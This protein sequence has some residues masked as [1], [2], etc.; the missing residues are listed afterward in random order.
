MRSSC[1]DLH[2]W[3]SICLES[4]QPL[5]SHPSCSGWPA[6]DLHLTSSSRNTLLLILTFTE[7]PSWMFL[8]GVVYDFPRHSCVVFF[9]LSANFPALHTATE[10]PSSQFDSDMNDP[11]EVSDPA[12]KSSV[13]WHHPHVR[14]D[15]SP[16][17]PAVLLIGW[18]WLW[19]PHQPLLG[20]ST[21]LE[22]LTKLRKV[23]YY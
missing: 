5:S 13:L 18:L 11:E 12:G 21:S 14:H 3:F 4:L 1:P 9:P 22:W 23:L 6:S 17:L 8:Y 10:C 2:T 20:L 16:R 7:G 19:G 15:T